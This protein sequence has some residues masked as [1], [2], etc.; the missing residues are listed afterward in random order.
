MKQHTTTERAYEPRVL[1]N[2]LDLV[3]PRVLLLTLPANPLENGDRIDNAA[4]ALLGL[5][6][7][8]KI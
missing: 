4:F 5:P 7:A 6:E 2:T 8:A 1:S 3:G